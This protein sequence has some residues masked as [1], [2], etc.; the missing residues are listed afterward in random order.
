MDGDSPTRTILY[1][2]DSLR[3]DAVGCYG[4][5][6][7]T[8][9]I[10][11]VA[12]DGITFTSASS[13]GIW[14]V[15]SSASVF[16]GL[17]P[18]AHQSLSFSQGLDSGLPRLTDGL[19]DVTTV[20]FSTTNG[21]S[22]LRGYD[23]GFDEFYQLG[24]NKAGLRPDIQDR[25][26]DAL[27]TWIADHVNEDFLI[28]VWTFGTHHPYQT[29]ASSRSDASLGTQNAMRRRPVKDAD[30][31]RKLYDETVSYCDTTFGDLVDDLKHFGI[32]DA[33]NILITADHGEIFNEHARL[34]HAWK[35]FRTL[36]SNLIPETQK[37]HFGL[38]D[39]S[40]FIGHQGIM[41]YE[42]LLSV[43]L[44]FK[45]GWQVDTEVCDKKVQLIDLAP[46]V[47]HIYDQEPAFM[48]GRDLLA[49]A[50]GQEPPHEYS[51][52]TSR[53]TGGP[54]VYRSIASQDRKLVELS[55]SRLS[56]SDLFD[57]RG[58]QSIG[59]RLI[60]PRRILFELSDEEAPIADPKTTASLQKQLSTH[61]NASR[62]RFEELQQRDARVTLSAD[63]KEQL[64]ELGYHQ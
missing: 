7:S 5:S 33:T 54:L 49:V 46:T 43:P 57:V 60:S 11:S 50:E 30:K 38:F 47:Q 52:S 31:L 18:E 64:R 10:D 40:A 45:P 53:V 6:A 27:Q 58:L 36:L 14:T 20:C 42:E 22:E 59:A 19:E 32:Y 8:P 15:P 63:T 34:E 39:R 3:R 2:F 9:T 16:T 51:F 24:E 1:V 37:R 56:A 29:P 44:I 25:V 21:V 17:Y 28:V 41:P 23:L 55:L 35:P 62:K 26:T 48:Q 12:G 4:G 61:V 13:Q